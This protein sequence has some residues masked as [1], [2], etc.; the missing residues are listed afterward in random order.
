MYVDGLSGQFP[1]EYFLSMKYRAISCVLVY[2]LLESC[3]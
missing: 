1:Y 3:V 2:S